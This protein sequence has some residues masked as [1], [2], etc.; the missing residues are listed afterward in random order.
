MNQSS[1]ILIGMPGAGK[2]T[3]GKLLAEKLSAHF[4]DGDEY[5]FEKTGL[6]PQE[7][8]ST[9]GEE[10]FLRLE[11]EL[12]I[13][14]ELF[15]NTPLVFAPGGSAIYSDDLMQKLK[16]QGKIIFLN[17][18]FSEIERRINRAAP[19][20]IIGLRNKTLQEL[21]SERIPL[22]KKYSDLAVS[23]DELSKDATIQCIITLLSRSFIANHSTRAK[24]GAGFHSTKQSPR[25]PQR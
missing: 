6:R 22:Y 25:F 13:S 19:R 9:H 3:I 15:A 5:I 8:I 4:V 14:P 7:I 20:G 21:Y 10:Y 12:F 17:V 2:S 23:C 11:R 24:H 1:V 16:N 18:P